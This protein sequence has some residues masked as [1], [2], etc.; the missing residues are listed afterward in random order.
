MGIFTGCGTEDSPYIPTGD[1]LDDGT[2]ST[3]PTEP[4]KT[5]ELIM[6]YYPKRSMNP[7]TSTDLTNR[8][9]FPLLYQGL[10]TVDR[11][12]NIFPILCQSYQVSGDMRTYTFHLADAEFSD[13]TPVTSADVVASLN[14][15]KA[16]SYYSGRFLHI[17][18]I[19]EKD[20]AVVI[21]AD[22]PMENMP[23][24]LDIPI[25]KA[26]ETKA[27]NPL[28]TGP[29]V[30]EVYSG[31]TR[32]R[33]RLGWWCSADM[34]ITSAYIPLQ[35]AQSPSQIRDQ[36]E[37]ADVGLVCTDP[38]SDTYADYRCDYEIWDCENGIFIYLVCNSSSKVFSKPAVRR[39]VTHAIDRELLA[40]DYYR[41]FARATY[42]PISPLS[43]NYNRRLAE[44]YGYNPELWSQAV[45]AAGVEGDSVTLLLNKDDS[46]R[47]RAGRAIAEM[48]TAG[49][50]KVVTAEVSTKEYKS[51]LSK[52]NFD[53]YL[54]QTKLS[55]N[56]DLSAFFSQSGKLNYGGLADTATYFLCT[57]SLANTGH[58][59][60]LHE[61]IMENGQLVPLLLRSYAVYATRGLATN[62][63]P[64]RDN[65][66]YYNLGRTLSDA[67]I[68]DK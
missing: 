66:F 39:A 3:R 22:T 50:L 62:L 2:G 12:Y 27:E 14:A 6:V 48:L 34:A 60:N 40:S 20:G 33:K 32:L 54:G 51:R 18:S 63:K 11:D 16:G 35:E 24:L 13:G 55:P 43:P 38:G 37:F 29:Y 56:M 23:V 68:N 57:E 10:F 59:Y 44:S 47:L 49:G 26:S 4:S 5:Q 21:T 15:A 30:W 45:T 17:K 28:G 1:A 42:L 7:Y 25:V 52:G 8:A 46:L 41:G 31:G 19:K 65:V 9:L 53:L 64:S 67:L 58:Y 61:S 36:F